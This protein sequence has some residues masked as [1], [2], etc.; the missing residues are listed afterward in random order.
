MSADMQGSFTADFLLLGGIFI[1]VLMATLLSI[2]SGYRWA[3]YREKRHKNEKEAPVGAMVGALLGLLAFILAITFSMASDAFHAREQGVVDEANAIRITY[4]LAGMI[5]E[6]HRTEVHKILREYVEERLQWTGVERT[7]E[8]H[9]AEELQNQLWAQVVAVGAQNPGGLNVFLESVDKMIALRS[10]RIMLRERSQI[11]VEYQVVLFLVAILAHAAMGYH[12]G[13]AG[14]ARSPVAL[15]V[16]IAFSLVM[17]L[18]VDIDNPG[19]GFVNI[20]Q[21]AMIDLRDS[22]NKMNP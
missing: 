22:L 11:P 6:P 18:I 8:G 5:Q 12:A 15:A 3:D 7:P 1:L 20:R 21:Q 19:R 16:A 4:G 17:M 13:I 9:S 14:T 2:E 10:V